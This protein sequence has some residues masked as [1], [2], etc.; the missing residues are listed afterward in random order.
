MD[1]FVFED[2]TDSFKSCSAMVNGQMLIF[3]GYYLYETQIA[4]VESCRL[5]RVGNLPMAFT[6]GACNTFKTASGDD[7][8][9]LCFEEQGI[10]NCHR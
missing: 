8:T 4:I 3:G 6:S 7:E 1:Q 9:L 2:G 5:T 10:K